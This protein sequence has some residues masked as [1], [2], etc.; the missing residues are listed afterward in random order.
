MGAPADYRR[1]GR[2]V[3]REVIL[4]DGDV[5]ALLLVAEIFL[6]EG[7]GVVLGMARYEYLPALARHAGID[8]R[9]FAFGEDFYFGVVSQGGF[10]D[11]GIS[12]MGRV[13]NIVKTAEKNRVFVA[14]G[15]GK[16]A[17][18]LLLKREFF[19]AEVVVEA[20]LGAPT[21]MKR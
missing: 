9:F 4:R 18:E 11:G 15:V 3:A 1:L 5:Y 6:R 2:V 21:Y 14:H 13:E 17:E 16:H 19:Y 8:A 20:R 12:R 10:I 7:V